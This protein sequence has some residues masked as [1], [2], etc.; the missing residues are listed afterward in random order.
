MLL[1]IFTLKQEYLY[2]DPGPNFKIIPESDLILPAKKIRIRP[3]LESRFRS[4]YTALEKENLF[5]V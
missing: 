4:K 2:L 1:Y 5:D 3:D